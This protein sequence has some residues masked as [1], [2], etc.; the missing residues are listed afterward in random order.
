VAAHPCESGEATGERCGA[1][2]TTLV[3]WMPP[4][5]RESHRAA[6]NSGAW[7]ANGA[8]R[9]RCC[10]TCAVELAE[11]GGREVRTATPRRRGAGI[12]LRATDDE[13]AEL[14]AAADAAGQ[15]LQAWLLSRA[16]RA[17]RRA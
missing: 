6:G 14:L 1:P 15:S 17:A 5:H 4:E 9:L 8:L 16:L 11:D 3:E 10:A 7:P 13:R 12:L 2:A